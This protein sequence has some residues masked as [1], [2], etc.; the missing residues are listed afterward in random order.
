MLLVHVK[1][2]WKMFRIAVQRLRKISTRSRYP[3]CEHEALRTPLLMIF[4]SQFR[5]AVMI[6]CLLRYIQKIAILVTNT[7]SSELFSWCFVLS[8]AVTIYCVLLVENWNGFDYV[9]SYLRKDRSWK[10][11]MYSTYEKLWAN[12][13]T[14]NL[15]K[16]RRKL[17]KCVRNAHAEFKKFWC[18][19]V[20]WRNRLNMF[21]K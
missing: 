4:C 6:Y 15:N 3:C 10:A 13:Q 11:Y 18:S 9:N 5:V 19:Y 16:G 17:G 1:R 14:P 8:I 12:K 21:D 7:K 20:N 2:S